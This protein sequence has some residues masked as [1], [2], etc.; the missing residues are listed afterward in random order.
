MTHILSVF[1]LMRFG[2]ID[3]PSLKKKKAY[4]V[5]FCCHSHVAPNFKSF[6]NCGPLLNLVEY[7]CCMSLH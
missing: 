6:Y 5:H 7:P 1:F 3:N 4:Y 2:L